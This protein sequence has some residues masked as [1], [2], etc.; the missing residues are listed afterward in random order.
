MNFYCFLPPPP[1]IKNRALHQNVTIIAPS[2]LAQ[3]TKP[4]MV[5]S[6]S[7]SG[8]KFNPTWTTPPSHRWCPN[9]LQFLEPYAQIYLCSNIK[10][11]KI[12]PSFSVKF[13]G[14]FYK[15]AHNSNWNFSKNFKWSFGSLAT[16]S[17]LSCIL[18]QNWSETTAGY[19]FL[20]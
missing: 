17:L 13:H 8:K 5:P 18:L 3:K 15:F 1:R 10:V 9:V 16:I 4:C 11:A 12:L 6:L 20:I 19:G 2:P 7:S 14:F